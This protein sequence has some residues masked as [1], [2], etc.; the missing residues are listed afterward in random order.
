MCLLL[1]VTAQSQATNN[2]IAVAGWS[3]SVDATVFG[4]RATALWR[5]GGGA[6]TRCQV[7]DAA[8]YSTEDVAAAPGA[9][10]LA[11]CDTHGYSAK[12]AGM[13]DV[14]GL[15]PLQDAGQARLHRW[16]NR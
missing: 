11:G 1:S 16:L 5:G 14:L 6:F 4:T 12:Q 10:A 2:Q 3:Q 8:V 7:I 9:T 13:V 15:E